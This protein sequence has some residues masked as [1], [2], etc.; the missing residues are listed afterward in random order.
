M[1]LFKPV[2]TKFGESIKATYHR[3]E[4]PAIIDKEK[5]SFVLASFSENPAD[6]ANEPFSRVAYVCDYAISSTLNPFQQGYE[7][8]KSLPEWENSVDC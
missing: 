6:T 1:A 2:S 7:Y 3:V 4:S 8:I 5:L